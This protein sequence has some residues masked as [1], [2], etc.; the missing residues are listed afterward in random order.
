MS[1]TVPALDPS[2]FD[3]VQT[4]F[5]RFRR[6]DGKYLITNDFGRY[7]FLSDEEFRGFVAGT[8]DKKALLY[9][10]LVNDGF[11]RDHLDFDG[12]A[13]VWRSRNRHLWQ[14][15]SLHV[16]VPTRRG[17]L[18]AAKRGAAR[19]MSLKT[20]ERVAA[21]IFESPSPSIAVEFQGAEPLANW[22]VVK[23]IIEESRKKALKTGKELR[24]SLVSNLSLMTDEKLKFLLKNEVGIRTALDG[25][26]SLHDKSRPFVGGNGHGKTV[27]WFRAIGEKTKN[28]PFR[29][30]AVLT[31]TRLSLAKHREILDE[32][33]RL[34]A[35]GI[36]L[37]RLSPFD[38]PR[39][40]WDKIGCTAEEFL[41]FYRKTLDAVLAL[42]K[43]KLFVEQTARI[44]LTRILTAAD[45]R[46]T[47]LRSPSGAGLGQLAYDVD[48]S[49]YACDE[50]LQ[51]SRGGDDSFKIGDVAEGTYQDL[52]AHPAVKA[53]AVASLLDNQ[54]ECSRCAYMPYHGVSPVQCY[55]EQ[56]DIMGR[57]PT[58][59]R[60]RVHKGILDYL[61]E[62]L[63][64][65]KNE[66]IFRKWLRQKEE[67][68]SCQRL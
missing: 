37:R 67:S 25:P 2:T 34:G 66:T 50:G 60:C 29:V 8:L 1:E 22:P 64:D 18:G 35:D 48:G 7:R 68:V 31:V 5:F 59:T 32:Y 12:L 53:L 15:P 11:I 27:R 52:A 28:K 54:P 61:F 40:S 44:F 17:E 9:T 14:G 55:V 26:A 41:E 3:P 30:S 51:V 21:R 43:R 33:V 58:N 46:S 39:K 6:L 57:M 19:E 24:L 49:V 16:V 56:G 65:E 4:G 20:A 23:L 62:K 38:V 63:Q 47:N 42:N 13:A 36:F 10:R 45:P